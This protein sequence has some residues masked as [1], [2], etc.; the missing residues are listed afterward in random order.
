M[1]YHFSTAPLKIAQIAWQKHALHIIQLYEQLKIQK[2]TSSEMTSSLGLYVTRWQQW[3]AG[4]LQGLDSHLRFT[5]AKS[6]Q[7]DQCCAE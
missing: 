6:N 7:S 4:G 2:A 5:F 1:G 3:A